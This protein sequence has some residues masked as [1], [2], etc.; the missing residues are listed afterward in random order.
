M[1]SLVALDSYS[2]WLTPLYAGIVLF[3]GFQLIRIIYYRYDFFPMLTSS[4]HKLR[5]FQVGFLVQL[6]F[7]ALIRFFFFLLLDIINDGINAE[8]EGIGWFCSFGILYWLPFNIQFSTFSLLVIYYAHILQSQK[9]QWKHFKKIYGA[10]WAVIN[11]L[12]LAA[13]CVWVGLRVYYYTIG[14]FEPPR[15]LLITHMVFIGFVFFVLVTIIALYGWK[16]ARVMKNNPSLV[17]TRL[18]AKISFPKILFVSFSL[19]VLFG[20]RCVYDWVFAARPY[21]NIVIQSGNTKKELFMF[22]GF[23]FWEIVPTILVLVLFGKVSATG[24]GA[25]SKSTVSVFEKQ[26]KY[27]AIP[28]SDTSYLPKSQLFNDPRRY[29]SD[30]ESSPLNRSINP[31]M[32]GSSASPVNAHPYP[33]HTVNA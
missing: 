13:N 7:W 8:E 25:W 27:A 3:V 21:D 4:R 33:V 20:S 9:A 32:Y 22:M 11:F 29:E 26:T 28:H 24:L 2:F 15:W 1:V 14:E 18:L 12:F 23:F 10:I 30:E 19:F 17:Q 5:S 16:T 31:T 6:F